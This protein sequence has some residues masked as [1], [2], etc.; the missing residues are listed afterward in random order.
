MS[1]DQVEGGIGGSATRRSRKAILSRLHA[2]LRVEGKAYEVKDGD[3]MHF[4][5]NV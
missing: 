4:R 5:F 2:K 1:D 3:V